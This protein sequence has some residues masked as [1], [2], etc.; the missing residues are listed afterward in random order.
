MDLNFASLC[1]GFEAKITQ[2][3]RSEKFEAKISEKKRKWEVKFYSEIVKHMWNGS[4]FALFCLKAK[5][6]FKRNG[7]TLSTAV[8][9]TWH[10]A[11]ISKSKRSEK[12]KVKKSEKID[13]N[14]ASLCFASKRKLLKW[15]EAKNLKRK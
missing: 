4:K 3:K 11:K 5:K 2:V 8:H 9:I 15:S 6:I 7:L 1:F 12:F 13:L 14:F 10:G